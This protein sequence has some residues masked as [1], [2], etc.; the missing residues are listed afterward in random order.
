M[1]DGLTFDVAVVYRIMCRLFRNVGRRKAG[2]L[3]GGA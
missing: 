3:K 1:N 2:F